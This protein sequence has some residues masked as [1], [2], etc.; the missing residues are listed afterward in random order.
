MKNIFKTISI[1]IIIVVILLLSVFPKWNYCLIGICINLVLLY[2]S[3]FINIFY[4]DY[5]VTGQFRTKMN[6]SLS[7]AIANIVELM[8]IAE[9][10]IIIVS[11]TLN[12]HIWNHIDIVACMENCLE[13]NIEM[14]FLCRKKIYLNKSSRLYKFL[15]T[16]IDNNR[17]KLYVSQDNLENH[18][19]LVDNIHVRFEAKHELNSK[20][21]EAIT[22]YYDTVL[23]DYV[24][25]K[26]MQFRFKSIPITKYNFNIIDFF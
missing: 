19:I 10:Q 16:Q 22:K 9:E 26:Y 3:F 6:L 25:R 24:L 17:I 18:F 20:T 1:F 23:T 8:N 12:K 4:S 13:R 5:K 7:N 21:R 11:S 2:S 15:K 14:I